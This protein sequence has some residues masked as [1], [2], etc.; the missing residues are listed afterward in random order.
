MIGL[1]KVATG[2]DISKAEKPGMFD[3]KVCTRSTPSTK[4]G[5]TVEKE[6]NKKE[7]ALY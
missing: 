5:R 1:Y 2:E 6:V 7:M 3:L 4:C